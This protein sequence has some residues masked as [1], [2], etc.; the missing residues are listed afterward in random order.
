[1]IAS[2]TIAHNDFVPHEL[3]VAMATSTLLRHRHCRHRLENSQS[4]RWRHR[5]H[6][7]Q[8]PHLNLTSY[9]TRG[10]RPPLPSPKMTLLPLGIISKPKTYINIDINLPRDATPRYRWRHRRQR[11]RRVSVAMIIVHC[12]RQPITRVVGPKRDGR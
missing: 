1:M 7:K 12:M 5:C 6:R 9:K 3:A 11:E 8:F 4:S 2:P 10:S